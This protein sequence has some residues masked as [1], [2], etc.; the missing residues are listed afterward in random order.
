MEAKAFPAQPDMRP[1]VEE[2][3]AAIAKI[4]DR[5]FMNF[6]NAQLAADDQGHIWFAHRYYELSKA[7]AK[8]KQT[9]RDQFRYFD[10]TAWHEVATDIK[11]NALPIRTVDNGRFALAQSPD[12]LL[13]IGYSNGTCTSEALTPDDHSVGNFPSH[14]VDAPA[15]GEPWAYY[16]SRLLLTKDGKFELQE[17][18]EAAPLLVD[19]DGRLWCAHDGLSVKVGDSWVKGTMS[20]VDQNTQMIQ[21][22]DKRIWVLNQEA[23]CLV[24]IDQ[25]G[26][27]PAIKEVKRWSWGSPRT[28][29]PGLA[30]DGSSYLWYTGNSNDVV[31]LTL[32]TTSG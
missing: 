11:K 26:G 2:N 6:N 29:F 12:G 5:G 24:T 10:G 30:C 14:F 1:L 22:P 16:K 31:R 20:G 25:G 21:T 19:A 17:N 27:Q 7:P 18:T 15:T 28:G 13:S 32:P 8:P 4:A 9:S 23:L 3:A